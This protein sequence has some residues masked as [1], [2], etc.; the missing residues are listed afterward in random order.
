MSELTTR[1]RFGGALL[2]VSLGDDADTTGAI[3]GLLAGAY[4]GAEAI[5]L[6]W[7][8]RLTMAEEIASMA[9]DFYGHAWRTIHE[10]R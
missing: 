2:A 10:G 1:D 7:R 9:D 8:Q 5:P 3:Y 6:E 4:Y